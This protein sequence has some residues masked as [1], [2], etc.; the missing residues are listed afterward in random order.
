MI[1]HSPRWKRWGG[2]VSAVTAGALALASV[3][4]VGVPAASASTPARVARPAATAVPRPVTQGFE[5]LLQYDY[6]DGFLNDTFWRNAVAVSTIETYRQTTGDDTYDFVFTGPLASLPASAYEDNLDDDSGWWGL[7]WLQAYQI[8]HRNSDLQKAAAIANYIDQDWNKKAGL[9]GDGGVPETRAPT[10]DLG[11]AIA[12]ELFLELTAWLSSAYHTSNMHGAPALAAMYLNEAETE[13]KWFQK[14]G[15]IN[16]ADLVT[17]SITNKNYIKGQPKLCTDNIAADIFTYNQGVILAGLT[18]LYEATINNST[19]RKDAP[20][21]LAIAKKI[22]DAVLKPPTPLQVYNA[23][24]R[25]MQGKSSN[26]LTFFGV[27][28]EPTNPLLSPTCCLGDGAAF[29]GIF[30]RDLRTL[31]D[32]LATIPQYNHCTAVYDDVRYERCTS[33]YNSFFTV[34][35]GSIEVVDSSRDSSGFRWFGFNWSGPPGPYNLTTQVS[36]LEALV[37]AIK[38]P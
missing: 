35:K 34:Q 5:T 32:V 23:L 7:A 31:D 19:Y 4:F 30:V 25:S 38:E 9:C 14:V 10:T 16:R 28:N 6:H 27:L 21:Y 33:L 11:G 29:K 2:L 24:V 17:N 36:A 22:A 15:L 12:N 3:A 13:W 26:I 20:G 37:A 1:R 8:T 18:R